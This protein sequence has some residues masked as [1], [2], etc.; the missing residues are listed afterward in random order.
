MPKH[1]FMMT[2]LLP[3]LFLA[4]CG[5][6]ES[7]TDNTSSNY[8]MGGVFFGSYAE[9]AGNDANP[10]VG[11][12]YLNMPSKDSDFFGRMSFQ[13]ADCQAT[14]ALKIS[15]EK[16]LKE[17]VLSKMTGVLDPASSSDAVLFGFNG[18]YSSTDQAYGGSYLRV[19]TGSNEARN[20]PDCLNYTL[21]YKGN[22]V[23]WA[24][25]SK[26]PSTFQISKASASSQV[27]TWSLVPAAQKA[28]VMFLKPAALGIAS[29][30]AVV[31]QRTANAVPT[32]MLA[33]T[34]SAAVTYQVVVQ[35]FD[36]SNNLVAYGDEQLTF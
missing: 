8:G 13:Y 15:G 3:A 9:T 6:N 31:L 30:N 5:E 18:H 32:T 19:G 34:T 35:L 7:T 10:A 11:G 28:V 16:L 26:K 22:W 14:N 25:G 2:L 33:P 21:A 12:L 24:K 23:A 1:A 20:A 4:G 36:A 29:D 17:L 27:L